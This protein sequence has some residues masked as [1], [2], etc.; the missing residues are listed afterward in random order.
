MKEISSLYEAKDPLRGGDKSLIKKKQIGRRNQMDGARE[1]LENPK[2]N[3]GGGKEV[4][5]YPEK[6]TTKTGRRE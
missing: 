5:G 1:S 6:K 3:S 2:A 4:L